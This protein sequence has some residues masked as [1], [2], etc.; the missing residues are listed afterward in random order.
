MNL[1]WKTAMYVDAKMRGLNMP[2]CLIKTYHGNLEF[3]DGN[4]DVISPRPLLQTFQQAFAEDYIATTR[5][6]IKHQAYERNKL[7]LTHVQGELKSLHLHSS[8]GWHDIC[9]MEPEDILANAKDVVV[10]NCNVRIASRDDE[11]RIFVYHIIFEQFNINKWDAQFVTAA[12]YQSFADEYKIPQE[13]IKRIASRPIGPIELD[14]LRP[15]WRQYYDLR[16]RQTKLTVWN[17]FLHF[18][19]LVRRKLR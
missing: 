14:L 8:A 1:F 13:Q 11:A 17:R 4:L 5:D 6:R 12:D 19:Y 18:G 2:Y 10:G 7:M 9:F 3:E 15:I 16:K